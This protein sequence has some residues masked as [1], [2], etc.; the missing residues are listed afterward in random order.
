[1]AWIKHPWLRNRYFWTG[2]A[3]AVYMLFFDSNH[4]LSLYE[5]KSRQEALKK[6]EQWYKDKIEEIRRKL[7]EL[8][9]NEDQ[10][11]KFA[12]ESYQMKRMDEDVFVLVDRTTLE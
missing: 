3:F 7:M 9:S 1:M 5:L 11:E 8:N 2:A 4:L 10:L 6:D 12:R